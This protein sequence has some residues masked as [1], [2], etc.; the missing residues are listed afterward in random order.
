VRQL[1]ISG[2][3][4]RD[5]VLFDAHEQ[6]LEEDY[7]LLEWVL[8]RSEPLALTLEYNREELTLRQELERLRGLLGVS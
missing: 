8:R 4:L 3:R 6:L 5:G 7:A 2:P 1:H